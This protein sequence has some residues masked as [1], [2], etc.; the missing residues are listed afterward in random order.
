MSDVPR[1]G[2]RER[3]REKRLFC[4]SETTIRSSHVFIFL[5]SAVPR[6]GVCARAR[7]HNHLLHLI[8][9]MVFHPSSFGSGPCRGTSRD[10]LFPRDPSRKPLLEVLSPR[11]NSAPLSDHRDPIESETLMEEVIVAGRRGSLGGPSSFFL[12]QPSRRSRRRRRRRRRVVAV[13]YIS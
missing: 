1:K 11:P 4:G 13:I 3:E 6:F 10:S 7:A 9:L 8:Y 5:S 2:G 12:L